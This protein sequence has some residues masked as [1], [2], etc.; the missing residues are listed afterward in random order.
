LEPRN[1]NRSWTAV[2]ERAGVQGIRLHDLRHAAASLAFAA[3]ADLKEVQA[4]LQHTRQ[5]TT[6]DIYVHVYESVRQ[7]TAA[8]MDGVLRKLGGA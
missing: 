3:G 2:C 1:V 5:G 8:R 6:A 7:G 4:M